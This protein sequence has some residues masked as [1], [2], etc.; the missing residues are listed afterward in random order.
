MATILCVDDEPELLATLSEELEEAGY[1]VIQAQDGCTGVDK[2]IQHKPDL[3]VSDITM[4]GKDGFELLKEIREHHP[5]LADVPV[6]F[7]S[8]L[9]GRD[10]ILDGVHH[11]ADDYLTKPVDF[12]MLH[13][14]ITAK[15]RMSE[16]MISRKQHEHVKLYKTL[17]ERDRHEPVVLREVTPRRIVLVGRG[18]SELGDIRYKLDQLGHKTHTFTSG[19]VYLRW[20]EEGRVKAEITFLW[21]HTDDMQAPM[22]RKLSPSRSGPFVMVIPE[23]LNDSNRRFELAGFKTSLAL[24]TTIDALADLIEDLEE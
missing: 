19:S 10:A 2:A 5:R 24:P 8:A 13:A 20:A 3:I 15:L 7:L 12:D 21:F 14:K 11:G 17:T 23:R 6:I 18:D 4:P 1:D 16:R 22:I 9:A